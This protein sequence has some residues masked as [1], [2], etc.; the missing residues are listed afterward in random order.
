[1]EKRIGI[2]RISYELLAEGLRFPADHRLL[3]VRPPTAEALAH[4][5]AEYVVEGPQMPVVPE[6]MD[7]PIIDT[8]YS[9]VTETVSFKCRS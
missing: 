4:H 9:S 3:C 8:E 2:V 1:M 5:V 7:I 6:G